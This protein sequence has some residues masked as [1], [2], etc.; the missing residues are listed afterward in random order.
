MTAATV[1]T[2][3]QRGFSL[4]EVLVAFAILAVSFGVLMQI[5]SRAS[6]TTVTTGQYSRAVSL[7]QSRLAA[8]GSAI[9]LQPGTVAGEREDGFAWEVAI[10]PIELAGSGQG[11]AEQPSTLT[12]Y[13]VTVT[14][15]WQDGVR[16]RHV[17]LA[18]L[19]LGEPAS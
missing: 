1:G 19:R 13:R 17:T 6:I 16:V 15:V 9:A 18:T 5:F 3:R 8:V 7:A 4:L 2:G 14:V 10:V 11:V 12:P